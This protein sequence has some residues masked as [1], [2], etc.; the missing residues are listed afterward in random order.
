MLNLSQLFFSDED[1]GCFHAKLDLTERERLALSS[2]R[3]LIRNCLRVEIP[4]MLTRGGYQGVPPIPRF[5]TQGSW[6]YKT[7]NAPAQKPQQADLDDGCYLP[8]S[9]V[10][11]TSRPSVASNVFFTAVE[12]ALMPLVKMHGWA[13]SQKPT[14]VR[15]GLSPVAHIDVPLYAIPDAEF[16]LLKANMRAHAADSAVVNKKRDNW[17]ALPRDKVLLAHRTEDWIKSDPRA[18][19]DWFETAVAVR[20]GQLR[21]IIRYLKAYRDSRWAEGGPSSILLMAAAEPVFLKNHGRDDTAL[22]EV[23]AQLPAILRKGVNSP[24]DQTETPL[25]T[26]LGAANVEEAA[27]AFEAL[28][29]LLRGAI[30]AGSSSQACTWMHQ[31]FGARFPNR[32]DLVKIVSVAATIAAAPAVAASHEIVPRTKAG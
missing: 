15:V 2:A 32:P 7:L 30:D 28:E 1:S 11:Q 23:V 16:E 18:V 26:R 3:A 4:R 8:M 13:L 12:A 20:G 21:R 14:C 25:T 27:K 6:A 17:A 9:F 31:A 5:Y 29:R 24:V 10:S 22:L 19:N